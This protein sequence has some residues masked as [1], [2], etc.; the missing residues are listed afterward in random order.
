MGFGILFVAYFL[1]L[2]IAYFSFTD[3]IL[4]LVMLLAFNKLSFV[5]KYFKLAKIPTAVFV[6]LGL[7]ELIVE[8]YT[9]F[10]PIG[11]LDVYSLTVSATRYLLIGVITVFMLLGIKVLAK[12]VDISRLERRAQLTIPFSVTVVALSALFEMP[13]L[14]LVL[15]EYTIAYIGVCLL[16]AFMLTLIF[17]L[18]VIYSAYMQIC[19]P[20][21]LVPKEKESRFKFVEKF[22][23]HEEEKRRE[24]IEYKLEKRKGRKK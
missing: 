3:A 23:A 17:N 8:V 14:T 12:E 15:N 16:L 1:F 20:S 7:V 21:Q 18:T 13:F 24:Y 4:G 19:M 22:K 6:L 5:N 2:N 9:M 10:T 11:E